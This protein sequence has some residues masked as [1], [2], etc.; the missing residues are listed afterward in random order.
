MAD[1]SIGN[2]LTGLIYFIVLTTIYF[3]FKAFYQSPKIIMIMTIIYFLALLI[4]EF[5]INV[6]VSNDLC[7]SRQYGT[8]AIVTFIPWIFIFGFLKMLLTIFPGWLSPFSNTFGYLVTKLFGINEVLNNILSTKFDTN[9]VPENM[10]IAAEALEHIYNDKSLLINEITQENFDTFWKRM[11]DS[12]FFKKNA[13]EFKEKLRN[14]V[15]MKD[16]VSEFIWFILSGGLVTSVSYNYIVNSD[17]KKS[18]DK[19]KENVSETEAKAQAE[20][21]AKNNTPVRVYTSTE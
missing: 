3:G 17:C 18:A 14:F 2:S 4:G 20:L 9:D 1:I 12:G 6:S 10:K 5:F 7:G 8:A 11:S 21:A 16:T 15:K 13:G 19:M